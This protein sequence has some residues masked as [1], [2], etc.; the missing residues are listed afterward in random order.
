MQSSCGLVVMFRN[1]NNES[2]P[3]DNG[4]SRS[5]GFGDLRHWPLLFPILYKSITFAL[6]LIT[7]ELAEELAVG[8][9]K[10]KTIAESVPKI[11]GGSLMGVI[12]VAII[13]SVSLIP[14]LIYREVDRIIGRRKPRAILLKTKRGASYPHD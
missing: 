9:F 8:V 7:F 5:V 12:S 14:S 11:G 4:Y 6:I 1:Q 10:G 3:T 2:N 13:I